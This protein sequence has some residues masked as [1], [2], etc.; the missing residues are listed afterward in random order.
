M[1]PQVQ[2]PM[3]RQLDEVEPEDLYGFKRRVLFSPTTVGSNY[4]K[5]AI[6]HGRPGAKSVPHTHPGGEVAL[7]LKG[8][9]HLSANGKRFELSAGTAVAVPP[10]VQHPA[11]STGDEDWVVVTAYCDECPLIRDKR[12]RDR[13]A[14]ITE[15]SL[16][17]ADPQ[18]RRLE[19]VE[20]EDLYGFERRVLFSPSTGNS[21]YMKF[22]V[23]RGKPGAKSMPHTHPGGEM[24]LTLEGQACLIANGKRYDLKAGSAISVPAGVE[25][26]AE[27]LGDQEWVVV[28]GYCD[29]CP[30]LR[31]KLAREAEAR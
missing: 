9:A 20:V 13:A 7:T 28:S 25:H 6:V 23:V 10:G 27:A 29:E 5:F 11:E 2:D 8:R 12:T 19:D 26:P 15:Q 31:E 3:L 21:P 4:M 24:S 30:L 16:P 18:V 14:G 17:P 1:T 22:A